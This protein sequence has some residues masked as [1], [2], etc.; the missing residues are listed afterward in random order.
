MGSAASVPIDPAS[1]LSAAARASAFAGLPTTFVHVSPAGIPRDECLQKGIFRASRDPFPW[2]AGSRCLNIACPLARAGGKRSE[3]VGLPTRRVAFDLQVYGNFYRD[4]SRSACRTRSATAE[5][6]RQGAT[7]SCR[8][9]IPPLGWAHA[10]AP[11]LSTGRLH[12]LITRRSGVRRSS[13]R[14]HSNV[15]TM[16]CTCPGYSK[17]SSRDKRKRELECRQMGA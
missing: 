17:T 15:S 3:P 8:G 11:S 14:I 13:E 10:L 9:N 4:A 1:R 12:L 2:I 5:R 6:S 16:P 7:A